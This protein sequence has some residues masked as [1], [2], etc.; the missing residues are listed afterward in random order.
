[1]STKPLLLSFAIATSLA[2]AACADRSEVADVDTPRDD[3][4]AMQPTDTTQPDGSTTGDGYGDATASYDDAGDAWNADADS[5]AAGSASAAVTDE[6][7]ALGVLNA[8]NE[9]EIAA[10][11]Q[12]IEKGVDGEVAEY[13]RMMIDAH[14]QNRE[15]TLALSP[16]PSAAPVQ[17]QVA[18][19]EARR[20]RLAENDGDAYARAYVDA[21][22]ADHSAALTKLDEQLIPAA[23]SADVREHLT[24]TREHVAHHLEQARALADRPTTGSGE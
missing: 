11:R 2:L 24:V 14:T 9:H 4:I 1:M 12:A 22:I 23:Q 21:M 19:G 17:L 6:R 5:A 7:A 3:S 10:S 16:D 18:E 8:I 15:Q 20:N 13:A